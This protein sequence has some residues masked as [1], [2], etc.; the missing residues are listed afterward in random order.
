[1]SSD[2]MGVAP[3]GAT[4]IKVSGLGKRYRLG[5]AQ[6]DLLSERIGRRAS[7]GSDFWALRGVD[8]EI[9]RGE[10]VG[11]V[12]RNGAGKSTL[13]KTL[14]RITPPTEGRIEMTGRVGTLLE[15]G[16]GFH[17]ELSGRENVFL[18][19][20]ILGMRRREVEARFDEIVA[21]SGIEKFLD[22]PVKRYSSGMYVRLA[23][24]VAAH[25]DTDIL[26]VDEVLA[27]GDAEFQRK[28]FGKMNDLAGGGR[29]VVFVSHQL[30]AVQRLCTRCYWID[31]GQ[32]RASGPTNDVVAAYLHDSGATQDG[33][34]ATIGPEV[35]R[36]TTGAVTLERVAMLGDDDQP[37]DRIEL[38]QPF[39][40]SMTFAVA[41]PIDDGVL[42]LGISTADGTRVATVQNVDGDR[43]L[44]N[45]QPGRHEIRA[46]FDI[47]LLPGELSLDVGMH[48]LIGL[49]LDFVERALTFSAVNVA[50]DG[51]GDRWPWTIVRG[52]LRPATQWSVREAD[53]VR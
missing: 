36:S 11:L 38:G 52:S 19:G 31:A 45:L 44:L 25:L 47:G 23:F 26:L 17:P 29:T 30:S 42:E 6:T 1:M 48:R 28:C 39:T 13:L 16:T 40:V 34:V 15:V 9:K 21:F 41:E 33:G 37:T 3:T 14:S 10:V 32:V 46:S 2:V 5:G 53:A 7:T 51:S 35:P 49:T 43:P 12:G 50:H 18:S 4:A 22:T 27:V 24:A 8:L 20:T